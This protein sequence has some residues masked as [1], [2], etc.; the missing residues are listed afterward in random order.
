[1]GAKTGTVD[2]QAIAPGFRAGTAPDA[3]SL[4]EFSFR[5]GLAL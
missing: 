2:N 1:V 3:N 4:H 5:V